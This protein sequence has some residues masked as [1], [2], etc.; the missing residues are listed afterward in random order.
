[1]S[2]RPRKVDDIEVNELGDGYIVYHADRDRVHFLNHTAAIVLEFCTG[3]NERT[4]IT[5]LLQRAYDLPEPPE[6]EIDECLAQLQ[7]EGLVV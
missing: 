3:E 4:E 7:N 1:V 6:V 2:K 5:R